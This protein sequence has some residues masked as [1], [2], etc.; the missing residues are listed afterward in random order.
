[1]KRKHIALAALVVV[2]ALAGVAGAFVTGF[3]PALGGDDG[4][5][6]GDNG[7]AGGDDETETPSDETVVVDDND[8]SDDGGDGGETDSAS[9]EPFSFVIE[10]IEECG[11]TCRDVTA[12]ITNNQDET[13]TGV[14]VRSEIYTGE[15]YDNKIWEGTS[16]VGELSGGESY[17]DEKRVDL[18]LREAYAVDQNDGWILIETYV[19]TDDKTYVFKEERQVA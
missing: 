11:Q 1:M 4:A 18:S 12:S 10:D 15:D 2:V 8:S 7:A 3:G 19:V 6:G 16:E 9:E 13:A 5:A 14:A 17:T